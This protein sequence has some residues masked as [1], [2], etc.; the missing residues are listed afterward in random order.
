MQVESSW[1]VEKQPNLT[2]NEE[3]HPIQYHLVHNINRSFPDYSSIRPE[4]F[5]NW[6]RLLRTIAYVLRYLTNLQS[7][8]KR[9]SIVVLAS[10]NTSTAIKKINHLSASELIAAETI[11][12][13]KC[14]HEFYG[15]ELRQLEMKNNILPGS[16]L[17][18]LNPIL[19]NHKI[20]RVSTRLDFAPP[21]VSAEMRR[22]ILLDGSHRI[23]ILI[24][25]DLHRQYH[26]QARET[27]INEL[28]K[29]FWIPKIRI[30]INKVITHCNLCSY[31]RAKPVV[32]R[33][34]NLP[35]ER[36]APFTP[37]FSYTRL[38]YMGPFEVVVGRRREKRWI[39][40]FTCLTMRAIHLEVSCSLD[41]S[42]CVMCVRNFINRRGTPLEIITDNGTNLRAAEKELKQLL[43]N[44]DLNEL[45]T[46]TQKLSPVSKCFNWKFIPPSAPHFGGAWERMVRT[47]KNS[48]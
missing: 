6:K 31:R 33:M 28:R 8:R 15:K 46:N 37:P 7:C 42:S 10:N 24:I 1:P 27:V 29:R 11:L 45:A 16:K 47:V 17:Y 23:T 26:H 39:A 35:K 22:P 12:I 48:L 41:T 32:P 13:K 18:N 38:D 30:H 9:T 20:L 43:E 19:D 36:L 21:V 4:R 44:V 2:T 3:E 14:Q 40:L 25:N 5:S 34:A